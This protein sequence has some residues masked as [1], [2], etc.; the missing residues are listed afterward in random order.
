MIETL[1]GIHPNIW[2]G[3]IAI[4]TYIFYKWVEFELEKAYLKRRPADGHYVEKS[5]A[6]TG[7]IWYNTVTYK[8]GKR[9]FKSE[10]YGQYAMAEHHRTILVEEDL[11]KKVKKIERL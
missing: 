8:R 9:V 3:G 6:E 10:D 2:V 7:K 1:T 5:T 4:A 11:D